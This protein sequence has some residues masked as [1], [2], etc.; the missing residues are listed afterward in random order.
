MVTW[1]DD[2]GHDGGSG[3]D[4]WAQMYSND[5]TVTLS[6]FRVN[7]YTSSTQQDPSIVALEDGGFVVTWES[8][9][10]DGDGYGIYGQRYDVNGAAVDEE[11]QVHTQTYSQQYDP[12]VAASADGGFV[13]AWSS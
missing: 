9:G 8:S 7:T 2:S 5:G 6:D 4:I 12:T 13:V 3:S 1:R 11:F 10:Q